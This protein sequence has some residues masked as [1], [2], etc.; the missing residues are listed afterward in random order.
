MAPERLDDRSL[1]V[2]DAHGI[3]DRL[4][5]RWREAY[6]VCAPRVATLDNWALLPV[7]LQEPPVGK[8]ELCFKP[9]AS[10]MTVQ[11]SASA[12]HM[13]QRFCACRRNCRRVAYALERLQLLQL[14]E[15][16]PVSAR[17]ARNTDSIP[18]ARVWD[19]QLGHSTCTALHA[20]NLD[21]PLIPS[22]EM[23]TIAAQ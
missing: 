9:R 4:I 15:G 5:V 10:K 14:F 16:E 6:A 19:P 13:Q 20:P 1:S 21:C 18:L 23:S 8:V 12:P 2:S 3:T 17:L 22:Q 7:R 11:C